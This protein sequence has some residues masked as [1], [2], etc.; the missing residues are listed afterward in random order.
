MVE[1]W[2]GLI[3]EC[4]YNAVN[5]PFK[6]SRCG[7]AMLSL[8]RQRGFGISWLIFEQV[9]LLMTSSLYEILW[10]VFALVYT[11]D[12]TLYSLPWYG[13]YVIQGCPLRKVLRT[14]VRSTPQTLV[15]PK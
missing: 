8:R 10:N 1:P 11:G 6:T 3:V 14:N 2:C 7:Y 9:V 4:M 13:W 12:C 5:I 15:D